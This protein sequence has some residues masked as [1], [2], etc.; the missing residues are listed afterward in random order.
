MSNLIRI[1]S[2]SFILFV[3]FFIKCNYARACNLI[4]W[5]DENILITHEAFKLLIKNMFT[6]DSSIATI[7]PFLFTIYLVIWIPY[8]QN[9]LSIFFLCTEVIPICCVYI[10]EG[11]MPLCINQLLFCKK[12]WFKKKLVAKPNSLY[13]L[14]K[15]YL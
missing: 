6:E 11:R 5:T 7:I 8:V 14:Y 15:N 9:N 4:I 12:K 13:I 2:R 1:T 10:E 3:T